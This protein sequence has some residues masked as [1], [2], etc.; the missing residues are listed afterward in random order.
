MSRMERKKRARSCSA[1]A[2]REGVS[3]RPRSVCQMM[4]GF[5]MP[6][7]VASS[8]S[9]STTKCW[10]RSTRKASFSAP[11]S[12]KASSMAMPRASRRRTSFAQIAAVSR[13]IA[14]APAEIG[15]EGDA[16]RLL[17]FRRGDGIGI[18]SRRRVVG[19]GIVDVPARHGVEE[20]REVGDV[21]RHR[22]LD[23]ERRPQNPPARR[24]S[25]ARRRPQPDHRAIRSPA[26]AASRHGPIRA[27]AQTSPVASATAPPPVEP[28][29]VSAVFQGLR[30]RPNT[31]LKVDPPAPNSGVFDFA[32][33]MPPRRSMRSTIGWLRSGT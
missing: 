26:G 15:G 14:I 12:G 1:Q 4:S 2:R 27:P 5:S 10:L 18:G 32:M 9:R 22:P 8:S 33:T 11:R 6:R 17:A 29:Q 23:G 13:S 31:S 24:A 16:H 30:V 25:R 7:L 28:P 20:Q 21:A 19:H 3:D